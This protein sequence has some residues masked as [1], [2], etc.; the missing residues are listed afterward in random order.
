MIKLRSRLWARKAG[1]AAWIAC[2]VALVVACGGGVEQA[3]R[4]VPGRVLVFGDETSLLLPDG[5]RWGINGLDASTGRLDCQLEPTWVQSVAADYGLVFEACNT[6]SPPQEPRALM[7]ATVQARVADVSDQLAA[8]NSVSNIRGSDLVL[9][10]AGNNDVWELY[11][12]YPIRGE[13]VLLN[14]IRNRAEQLA[15]LINNM[16]ARGARVVV[17]NLPDLGLS[18]DALEQ[19]ALYDD[20]GFDR[21]A[22]IT[23]LTLAFNERLGTKLLLDGRYIGLVQMD[24]R[25][26]AIGRSPGSYGFADITSAACRVALPDCTTNTLQE[27][28][29]SGS[30]LWADG[31]HFSSG[32]QSQIASLALARTR[33][34]PF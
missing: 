32:G 31:R 26:Q 3:E 15:A 25:S 10:M 8:L 19:K 1:L 7:F 4:F 23:R 6:G 5:R 11:G 29:G 14:D 2:T 34:N 9:V 33:G 17:V 13:T 22:L 27:G 12:Q 18:P 30:F 24:E 28:A 20:S 16:V 21:A